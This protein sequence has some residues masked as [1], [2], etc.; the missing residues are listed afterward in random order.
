MSK[1]TDQPDLSLAQ[2]SIPPASQAYSPNSTEFSPLRTKLT[3]P[4]SD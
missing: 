4:V 2:L 3:P 1:P